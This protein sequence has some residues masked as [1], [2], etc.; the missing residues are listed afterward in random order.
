MVP[1]ITNS[2]LV[3]G[4]RTWYERVSAGTLPQDKQ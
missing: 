4:K 1:R 2:V 3:P